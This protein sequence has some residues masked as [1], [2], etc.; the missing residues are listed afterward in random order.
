MS[1]IIKFKENANSSR[2]NLGLEKEGRSKF[3]GCSDMI[4]PAQGIDG[5]WKTGLDDLSH[6]VLSIRNSEERVAL[7]EKLRKERADLEA[8]TGL[9]LDAKSEFWHTYFVEVSGTRVLDLTNPL[10][11]IK[12]HVLLASDAVAPSLK[13][14]TDVDYLYAKYY[15]AREFEDVQDKMSKKM[16][17]NEA[18]TELLTLLKTPDRALLIGKYL[19]LNIKENTPPSNVYELFQNFLDDDDKL[20]SISKFMLALNMSPEEITTKLIFHDA[21]RHNVIRLRD[22]LY[23]RGNITMGKTANEVLTFLMD[24]KNSSELLSVQEEIEMK[25]KF[26]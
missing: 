23:Q 26:G 5:R 22:G 9:D 18:V 11:K 19:E 20:D 17:Y 3:P 2:T 4:Q 25:K 21:L 10:D 7:Q 8:L 12:Y 6:S 15:V 1:Q 16:R 14:T 24:I 13:H